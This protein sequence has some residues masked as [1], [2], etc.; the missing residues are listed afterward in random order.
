MKEL[1]FYTHPWSRG[2][3]AR[4]MLEECEANY[5]TQVLEYNTS[6]KADEYLAINPM[7]KVPALKH[8][9]TIVTENAAICMYLA[10]AFPEKQLAP[11]VNSAARGDYYRW[12]LFAAGPLEE[13]ATAKALDLLAPAEKSSM[14]GYGKLE[15]VINT[16]D[17]ALTNTTY[18]CGN[19]FST[20]DL[21]LSACINWYMQFDILPKLPSFEQ[22]VEKHRSR[23][24][25]LKAFA[26]DEEL[27]KQYPVPQ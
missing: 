17:K 23:A 7:G 8:G 18:L 25:G 11:A 13:V 22:Y 4:W 6:M 21:Y 1:I 5:Q 15:D 12:L 3:I 26:M 16:L 14:V 27:S 20:A 2:R 9:D 19:Q 24:A 10:D